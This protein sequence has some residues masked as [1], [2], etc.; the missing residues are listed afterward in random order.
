MSPY[1]NP[2]L[3]LIIISWTEY[4]DKLMLPIGKEGVQPYAGVIGVTIFA[5][6]EDSGALTYIY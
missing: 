1:G 4:L 6:Y 2:D 3:A 5:K